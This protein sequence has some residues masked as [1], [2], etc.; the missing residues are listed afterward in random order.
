MRGVK[1]P[2]KSAGSLSVN[3]NIRL[4]INP[5]IL[6]GYSK[7]RKFCLKIKQTTS[8]L[9]EPSE[10]SCT[11]GTSVML[12]IYPLHVARSVALVGAD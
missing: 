10:P 9:C 3:F 8:K 5:G 4:Q 11:N 1:A 6:F 2:V 12:T 7:I